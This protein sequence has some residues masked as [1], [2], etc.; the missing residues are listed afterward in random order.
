MCAQ[1]ALLRAVP[2]AP[3]CTSGG[4]LAEVL[5]AARKYVP[6]D[7]VPAFGAAQQQLRSPDAALRR[8]GLEQLRGE[9]LFFSVCYMTEY[10]INLMILMMI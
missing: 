5:N 8:A 6:K 1:R 7:A 9:F 2:P 3:A 10:F 4:A